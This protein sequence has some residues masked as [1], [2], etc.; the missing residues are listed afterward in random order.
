MP[1][2]LTP[3]TGLGRKH[4]VIAVVIGDLAAKELVKLNLVSGGHHFAVAES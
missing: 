4:A 2:P 3:A 1:L